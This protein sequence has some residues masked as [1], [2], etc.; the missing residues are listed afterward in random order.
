MNLDR[1]FNVLGAIV[2]VA[3]VAVIVSSPRTGDVIRSFGSAFSGA[4]S[5]ATQPARVR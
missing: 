4:I 1:V 5:A 2:S 3:M